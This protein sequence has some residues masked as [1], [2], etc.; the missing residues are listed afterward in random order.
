MCGIGQERARQG[1]P[2]ALPAREG[3]AALPDDGLVLL[4]EGLDELMRLAPRRRLR[5]PARAWHQAAR[6]R[7]YR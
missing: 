6:R 2:L 7:C 4:V 3:D 5:A 1:Q